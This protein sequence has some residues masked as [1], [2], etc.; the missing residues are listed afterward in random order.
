MLK[1]STIAGGFL[2]AAA[3]LAAADLASYAVG[4]G[5]GLLQVDGQTV[6]VVVGQPMAMLTAVGEQALRAGFWIE[7]AS[8]DPGSSSSSEGGASSSDAG[9]SS[10]SEGGASSSDAGS[11]S[12]GGDIGGG[13]ESALAAVASPSS[14][15]VRIGARQA[16]VSF[17]LAKAQSARVR[18]LG[19]D[20]RLLSILWE[21][22]LS[23][24]QTVRLVDLSVLPA[25]ASFIVIEAGS[26][27][28]TLRFVSAP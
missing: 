1:L 5:G 4:G 17:A 20:G 25:G 15:G 3:W 26:A 9:S 2:A 16:E 19:S 24:G 27:R 22:T 12:S 13:T 11:S 23:A 10:S 28:K 14:I 7:V 18:A 8:V 21:E 6:G